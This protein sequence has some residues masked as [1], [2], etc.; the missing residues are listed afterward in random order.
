MNYMIM[1]FYG[2]III[3]YKNMP[4]GRFESEYAKLINRAVNESIQNT[5]YFLNNI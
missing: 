5:Y 2:I 4:S 3:R 1:L